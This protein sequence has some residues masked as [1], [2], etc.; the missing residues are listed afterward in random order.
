MTVTLLVM[1]TLSGPFK[2]QG[3]LTNPS[4]ANNGLYLRTELV[5]HQYFN[6][7]FIILPR[8]KQIML[9]EVQFEYHSKQT[10]VIHKFILSYE[11][12]GTN[13]LIFS[14]CNFYESFVVITKTTVY[15]TLY[16]VCSKNYLPPIIII[17]TVYNVIYTIVA[18]T[19][20]YCFEK[21]GKAKLYYNVY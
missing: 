10:C 6:T 18:L 19:E 9:L 13:S 8:Q 11:S 14:N 7:K 12:V 17:I 1:F 5:P 3:L 16:I 4:S 15:R 20:L 21:R 2:V